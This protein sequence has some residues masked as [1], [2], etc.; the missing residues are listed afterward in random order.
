[1][2][3]LTID[4]TRNSPKVI[5]DPINQ[6]FEITGESRPENVRLFY[7]PIIR[8]IDDYYH[9]ISASILR[10]NQPMKKLTID[11]KLGYFNSSSAKFIFDLLHKVHQFYD[12]GIDVKANWFYEDNDEDM[13][14]A[15]IDLS[16]MLDFP[17]AYI[18][19]K[20]K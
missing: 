16:E 15:G 4:S 8:W 14:Q 3:A 2:D 7:E 1:M 10:G 6:V 17:F 18:P 13:K 12:H 19:T 20:P 9:E 11:I 5:L